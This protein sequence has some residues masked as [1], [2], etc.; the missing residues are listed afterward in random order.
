MD[1]DIKVNKKLPSYLER[2]G[3][4]GLLVGF[5]YV[6]AFMSI[7]LLGIWQTFESENNKSTLTSIDERISLIEEQINICLLYTSPSPRDLSTSRMPSS[8]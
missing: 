1:R 7:L 6:V 5:I 2:A 8:A 3:S 4:G